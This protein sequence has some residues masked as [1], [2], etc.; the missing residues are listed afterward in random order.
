MRWV[1]GVISLELGS[2]LPL[3]CAMNFTFH[4][5]LVSTFVSMLAI[6]TVFFAGWYAAKSP[7][8]ASRA[9]AGVE[10]RIAYVWVAVNYLAYISVCT[11]IF[12]TIATCEKFDDGSVLLRADH[13]INC[14]TT[15]HAWHKA[16][17]WIGVPLFVFG[18]PAVFFGLLSLHRSKTIKADAAA[19]EGG[20]TFS[21]LGFLTE[22]FLHNRYFAEPLICLQ[23]VTVAGILVFL[24]PSYAQTL[25][26]IVFACFWC[27]VFAL[28]APFRSDTEN[29]IN[30]AINFCTILVL[31]G[32]LSIKMDVSE[33]QGFERSLTNGLLW[34]CSLLPVVALCLAVMSELVFGDAMVPIITLSRSMSKRFSGTDKE[35]G[36]RPVEIELGAATKGITDDLASGEA[37]EC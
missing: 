18:C 21:P 32:A 12:H 8:T 22:A 4:T 29:V 16:L 1:E 35:P 30:T 5:K 36:Q 34:T 9:A 26:G 19:E 17:A 33:E 25:Y 23:K 20:Q 7:R 13:R 6:N 15:A 10:V 27:T 2:L 24:A 28:I 37:S 31:L 3:D 11:T 14:T